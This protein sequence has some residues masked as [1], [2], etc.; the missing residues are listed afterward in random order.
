MIYR[1]ATLL[2]LG[3]SIFILPLSSSAAELR[4]GQDYFLRKG[5]TVSGNLYAGGGNL[6]IAGD[7]MGDL[8]AAGGNVNVL[9]NVSEDL[10][11]AG[12]SLNLT[13][14]AGGDVRAAGGRVLL[15]GEVG[16][17]VALA[18][19]ELYV[20][21]GARIGKDILAGGG[22]VTI[23]GD[24]LGNVRLGGREVRIDGEVG[25]DLFVVAERITLGPKAHIKG[26]FSYRAQS[27]ARLEDGARV[28]GETSFVKIE[29]APSF[30][31]GLGKLLGA[32]II[33]KLLMLL[34]LGILMVLVFQDTS[35]S[36]V[37]YATD[38]FW[39][40]FLRGLIALIVMPVA[41]GLALITLI[42]IPIG[43]ILGLIYIFF[44]ILARV[45][46]GIIFG[47]WLNK[48][49]RKRETFEVNWQVA[50]LGILVLEIVKWVPFLG[51]VLSLVF[52][53]AAFGSV[54]KV[55]YDKAWLTR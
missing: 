48:V 42:G 40:E 28:E 14:S 44:I 50:V 3:L 36:L 21:P 29:T 7:V 18:G 32:W 22:R 34:L 33:L 16:G 37:R 52:F 19:G 30:A 41:A 6:S 51:W 12:G 8:L 11:A 10:T 2:V 31:K 5:E 35:K 24:V 49:L 13:G 27:E 47:S 54:L 1:K 38:R 26:N 39:V 15:S 17:D 9:G 43:I 25:G 55:W 4:G 53:L 23:E 46:A 45:Y 20:A